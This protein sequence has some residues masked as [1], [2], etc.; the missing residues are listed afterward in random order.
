M[1]VIRSYRHTS[2]GKPAELPDHGESTAEPDE[3]SN[4]DNSVVALALLRHPG[5]AAAFPKFPQG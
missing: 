3:A 4:D 2:S 5:A 1:A